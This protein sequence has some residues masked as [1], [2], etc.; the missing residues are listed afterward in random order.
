MNKL[1]ITLLIMIS[2]AQAEI[3]RHVDDEGNTVYSDQPS[4]NSEQLSL[5]DLPTYSAQDASPSFIEPEIEK[6][7]EKPI[8]YQITVMT[9]QPNQAFYD[10]TGVV[11]V[12]VELSPE[13]DIAKD[14]GII[15]TL[16]G[17][18]SSERLTQ[19]HYSFAGIERGSHIVLVSIVDTNGSVLKKSKSILFHLHNHAIGQ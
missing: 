16:D 15:Y 18:T 4:E 19:T 1:L 5:P 7:V 6:T 12:S 13:L 17:H 10:D 2:T 9:P 14:H 11:E 3:Y 8:Q